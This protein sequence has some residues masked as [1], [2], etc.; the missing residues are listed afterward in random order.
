M[1]RHLSIIQTI[2][3]MPHYLCAFKLVGQKFTILI[4]FDYHI[5]AATNGIVW[6]QLFWLHVHRCQSIWFCYSSS[7][8]VKSIQQ[9]QNQAILVIKMVIWNKIINEWS[10][11]T[12]SSGVY[13]LWINIALRL[14]RNSQMSKS[15]RNRCKCL[16]YTV[17]YYPC[18]NFCWHI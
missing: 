17:N 3:S 18:T 5:T 16:Q 15:A 9:Q 10:L 8:K 2:R 13:R 7:W 1:T 12:T 6:Y 14:W 11:K 4:A